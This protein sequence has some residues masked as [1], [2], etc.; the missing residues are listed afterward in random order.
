MV[1]SAY[2]FSAQDLRIRT[3]IVPLDLDQLGLGR[4]IRIRD[5]WARRELGSFTGSFSPEI[6]WHGARLYRVSPAPP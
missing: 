6:E 1:F 3:K 2:G 5:L 4:N